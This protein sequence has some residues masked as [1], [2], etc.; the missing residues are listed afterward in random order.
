MTYSARFL[1]GVSALATLGVSSAFAQVAIRPA[2]PQSQ[3]KVEKKTEQKKPEANSDVKPATPAPASSGGVMVFIDPVTHQIRQ[4]DASE[5]GALTQG[6]VVTNSLSTT[7]AAPVKIYGPGAGF[8]IKLDDS[9]M[10]YSLATVGA[11]GKLNMDC[12]TGDKAATDALANPAKPG[13]L[14]PKPAVKKEILDVQ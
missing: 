3:P 11:D 14:S 8:G 12:V 1:I 6:N 7:T 9:T 13:T 5:I 2:D 10:S 4:P